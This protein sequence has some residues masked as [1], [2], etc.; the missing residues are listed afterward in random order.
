MLHFFSSKWQGKPRLPQWLQWCIAIFSIIILLPICYIAIY[1]HP[2]PGDD[3]ENARWSS[4]PATQ[5]DL[6]MHWSGRYFMNV[7]T[8]LCPLLWRSFVAYRV[9]V[10]ALIIVFTWSFAWLIRRALDTFTDAP[11]V[12]RIAIS[13][14]MTALLVNNFYSLSESFYWFTGAVVYLVPAMLMFCLLVVLMNVDKL[15]SVNT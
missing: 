5:W 14:I 11:P 13:S 9:A 4:F 10:I 8:M 6:Y 3:F 2:S 1:D 12:T 7:L 15:T